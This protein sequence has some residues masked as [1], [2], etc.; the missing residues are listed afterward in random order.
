MS[1]SVAGL[2]GQ[3]TVAFQAALNQLAEAMRS[4]GDTV[5]PGSAETLDDLLR[6]FSDATLPTLEKPAVTDTFLAVGLCLGGLSLEA[7]LE[8]VGAEQRHTETKA[9][10]ANM[11]ARAQERANANAEKLEKVQEEVEKAKSKGFL[12]GLLKAFKYIGMA[13]AAIGAVAMIA[14]GAAGLA[15]GGSGA[16]LIGLGI[17]SLYMLADSITQEAT[18]GKVGIGP[19]FAAG[20]IAEAAGADKTAVQWIQF[21]V[22][23]AA[24]IAMA[25]AGGLA[26]AGKIGSSAAKATADVASNVVKE[27]AK[28]TARVSAKAVQRAASVASRVATA[29]GGVNTI[30]QSATTIASAENEKSISFLQA[31]RKRLDALLERIAQANNLDMEHLKAVMERAEQTLQQISDIVQEGAAANTA[32]LTGSPAMA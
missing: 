5:V 22:D 12:D 24:S 21:S 9:G 14:A 15:A 11:E 4:T 31:E 27:T 7:L 26:A 18:G 3:N 2:P 6:A 17:A 28:T 10:M 16:L 23:L 8:A 1:Q 20:K 13:L 25:V 19:G 32:L 30:A 29:A